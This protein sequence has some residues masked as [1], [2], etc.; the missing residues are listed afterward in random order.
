MSE[1]W[2]CQDSNPGLLDKKLECYLFAM[3]PPTLQLNVIHSSRPQMGLLNIQDTVEQR[4]FHCASWYF[5][6]GILFGA[7]IL[8]GILVSGRKSFSIFNVGS[9]KQVP[10]FLFQGPSLNFEKPSPKNFGFSKRSFVLVGCFT[11]LNWRCSLWRAVDP[12]SCLVLLHWTTPCA[13]AVVQV[14]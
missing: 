5:V 11:L 3:R 4:R 8:G 14:V 6:R 1:N 7:T 12:E 2:K 9:K 13:L 10:L